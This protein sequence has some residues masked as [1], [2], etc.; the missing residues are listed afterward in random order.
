MPI[1]WSESYLNDLLNEAENYISTK[2]NIYW[3]REALTIVADQS[4]YSLSP[5]IRKITKVMWKGERLAPINFDEANAIAW[6]SA[7]VSNSIKN[8]YASSKPF[9]YTLHPNN[10]SV[11]RLIPTPNE[12]ITPTG[13]ED[14][15]GADIST[16]CIISFYRTSDTSTFILPSYVSRR[17]KKAYALYRAFLKEGKGQNLI[18]SKYYKQKYELLLSYF[19]KI[20]A[21]SY[22]SQRPVLMH[23]QGT[24]ISGLPGSPQLPWN[25]PSR[26]V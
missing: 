5:Y 3:T 16:Q 22:I 7:V 12:S 26:K 25:Y 13:S 14:L 24:Y 18:A 4:T 8:E 9:Y 2:D 17:F 20:N 21:G 19:M 23:A 1:I 6:N 11:L 15:Y 10:L